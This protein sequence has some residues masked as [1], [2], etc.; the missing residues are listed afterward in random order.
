MKLI[1]GLGNPDEKHKY[2][3]HN[4]GWLT[5]DALEEHLKDYFV[6]KNHSILSTISEY[7]F[8][9]ERILLVKPLTYM[10]NSGE[11]VSTLSR[12]Y[13]V[14]IEDIYIVHD[15]LDIA[16][17]NFKIQKGRGPKIHNGILSIEDHLKT[18]NFYRIRIGVDNRDK[19]NRITGERY[20]LEDFTKEEI[21]ELNKIFENI[22]AQLPIKL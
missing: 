21:K 11:S 1:V 10:N 2:N 22:I 5:I 20:V 4:V 13:K 18:T 3:R 8:D 15:D 14:N 16:F 12:F 7:L 9:N 19:E 6:K 17:G